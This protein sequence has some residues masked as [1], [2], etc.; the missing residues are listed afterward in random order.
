MTDPF[1]IDRREV[2]EHLE[3]TR[4]KY[5]FKGDKVNM[6]ELADQV[7]AFLAQ[8]GVPTKDSDWEVGPR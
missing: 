4:T 1:A 3:R 8:K 2:R 6:G 7:I 5:W